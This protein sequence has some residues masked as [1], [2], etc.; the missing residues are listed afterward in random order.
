MVQRLV[1]RLPRLLLLLPDSVAV[2]R[3]ARPVPALRGGVQDRHR[4][5]AGRPASGHLLPHARNSHGEDR[6]DDRCGLGRRVRL[7]GELHHLW[8]QR[9]LDAGRGVLLLVVVLAVPGL[10]RLAHQGGQGRSE[11]RQVGCPRPGPDR[12]DARPHHHR[13]RV[14]LLVRPRLEERDVAHDR[15]L[16]LG[17]LTGRVLGSSPHRPDRAQLR[18]GLDP[19]HGLGG[20]LPRRSVASAPGGD[21]GR[22]LGV[23]AHATGRPDHRSHSAPRHLLP[24][25]NRP[26]GRLARVLL[27]G[28]LEALERPP[29][30]VLV[31]RRRPLRRDCP[32]CGGGVALQATSQPPAPAG[33]HRSVGPDL[34]GGRL[35]DS[36]LGRVARVESLGRRRCWSGCGGGGGHLRHQGRHSQLPDRLRRGH[37]GSGCGRRSHVR[38]RLVDLELRGIR[39]QGAMARVSGGR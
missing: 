34:L 29:S 36:R 18:H 8:R 14:C 37:P 26:P 27:R 4:A 22:G 38:G 15:G 2:H 12:I 35:V 33:H 6:G 31:L 32:G 28:A 24:A 10:S 17:V 7:D 3:G 13:C 11:V 5:G 1:R 20:D 9:R 19:A 23:P 25:A 16:G 21:T 39:G 30:P